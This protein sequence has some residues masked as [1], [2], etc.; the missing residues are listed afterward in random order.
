MTMLGCPHPGCLSPHHVQDMPLH[1]NVH[2][3]GTK[4]ASSVVLIAIVTNMCS[5]SCI[6]IVQTGHGAMGNVL[7]LRLCVKNLSPCTPSHPKV[8]FIEFVGTLQEVFPSPTPGSK[9]AT[10]N[11]LPIGQAV[12]DMH[13]R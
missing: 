3:L 11:P 4:Q 1:G 12:V 2:L 13:L 7:G 5:S 8:L 10:N 9:A 6:D